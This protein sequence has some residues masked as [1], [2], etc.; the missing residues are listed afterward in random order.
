MHSSHEP[1]PPPTS[2]TSPA[3]ATLPAPAPQGSHTHTRPIDDVLRPGR[4]AIVLAI[5]AVAAGVTLSALLITFGPRPALAG[6]SAAGSGSLDPAG[7]LMTAA[8]VAFVATVFVHGLWYR[9]AVARTLDEASTQP[10]RAAR[11]G[12]AAKL[13]VKNA[14]LRSGLTL[15][16]SLLVCTACVLTHRWLLLLL[17]GAALVF[18]LFELALKARFAMLLRA[19]DNAALHAGLDP[20]RP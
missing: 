5:S 17:P 7:L 13:V 9:K 14:Y 12:L 16:T 18:L 3:S 4:T 1:T 20:S 11:G 2:S 19:A 15:V 10:S 6:A 8:G